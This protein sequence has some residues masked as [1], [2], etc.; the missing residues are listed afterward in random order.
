MLLC[1]LRP[2]GFARSH[3]PV[4]LSCAGVGASSGRWA[5]GGVWGESP[6]GVCLSEMSASP[7]VVPGLPSLALGPGIR[8]GTT[9]L[10]VRGRRGRLC[11]SDGVTSSFRRDAGIQG[12]GGQRRCWH[13]GM[14][15][16]TGTGCEPVAC[17]P[18]HW[19]PASGPGRRGEVGAK[20]TVALRHSGGMPESRA[21]EG[22]VDAGA[23]V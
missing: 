13:R 5:S 18:W 12:Q 1:G 7:Q 8:A 6:C 21:T 17:H 20:T 16:G 11:R 4:W 9:G 14:R 10:A 2:V 23:E 3:A 19:V 15:G 22:D